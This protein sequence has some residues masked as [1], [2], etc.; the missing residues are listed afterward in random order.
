MRLDAASCL[1]IEDG[2]LGIEAAER[3]GMDWVR[4]GAP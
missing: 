2:D 1:V 3:A 4:V